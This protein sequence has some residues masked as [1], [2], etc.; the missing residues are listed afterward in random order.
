MRD[1]PSQEKIEKKKDDNRM[2]KKRKM[3]LNLD[4]LLMLNNQHSF[5]C[6]HNHENSNKCHLT[7]HV[8]HNIHSTLSLSL[9][10]SNSLTN[11]F[12]LPHTLHSL[13]ILPFDPR[14]DSI[15]QC[16]HAYSLIN[17]WHTHCRRNVKYRYYR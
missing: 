17:E 14:H 8:Y 5:R 6:K 3:S 7:P 2:I 9:S 4:H 12:H 11:I 15:C 13:H 16:F 10:L 1:G